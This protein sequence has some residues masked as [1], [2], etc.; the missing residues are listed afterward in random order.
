VTAPTLPPPNLGRSALAL[1][2]GFLVTAPLSIGTDAL[3]HAAGVFP[4]WGR[5]MSDGLFA[6]ATVYRVVYTVAGGYA[7]ARVA[8]RRP[9][10]H[11]LLG[12]AIGTVLAAAGA[13]ATWN[14]GPE[15]G[16]TWYPMALVLTALPCVWAGAALHPRRLGRRDDLTPVT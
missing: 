4:P 2:A 14:R 6:W 8:P 10:A 12:G 13:V 1:L 11:A 3:M 7:T 16:P 5:P 9:M 15:F